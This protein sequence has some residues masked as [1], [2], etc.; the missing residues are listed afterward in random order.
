MDD[1]L[2]ALDEIARW[3]ARDV[4]YY[5]GSWD[6][7]RLELPEFKTDDF[8]AQADAPANPYM[9]SVVRMPRTP[10]EQPIP[11]GVV[12][13]TYSLAQ[14][15]EVAEKC[16]EGIRSAGIDTDGLT[17]QLGLTE[18]GEWMNLRVLFPEALA[19]IPP[20]GNE[21]G[22]RLECYN[23]VDGSSRLVLFLRWFRFVCSNGLVI[24]ETVEVLKDIH[25]RHLNLDRIPIMVREGMGFVQ[26]DRDKLV[27]WQES[28]IEVNRLTSWFDNVLPNSWG[29]KSACR[30]FHICTSGFDVE[31]SDPFAKGA[32]TTKAVKQTERVPG[33][34][35]VAKNLYDLSQALSWVASRR[36]STDERVDWQSQIPKL[37]ERAEAALG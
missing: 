36:V 9:R 5:E 16:L 33:S 6:R 17:C 20:D 35:V 29:K 10:M 15:W 14:H 27:A 26:Q 34:P 1:A 8:R 23:S 7:L 18:F 31:Y 13:N 28:E 37:V 21:L 22:L 30:V 19:H 3:H 24:G 12:S 11:V 25:N 4:R 32:P 2:R